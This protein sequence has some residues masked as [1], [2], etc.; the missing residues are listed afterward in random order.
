LNIGLAALYSIV[1]SEFNVG[2]G[3]WVFFFWVKASW[4]SELTVVVFRVQSALCGLCN[5][6][7]ILKMLRV[8][9][10]GVKIVLEVLDEIH[11]VLD[12]VIS[13]DS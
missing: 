12:K 6:H 13:S 9:E 3:N 8:G 7:E 4:V 2:P 1:L 5:F 11:M 10:V